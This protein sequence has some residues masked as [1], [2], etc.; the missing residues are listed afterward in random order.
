MFVDRVPSEVR[1]RKARLARKQRQW[2]EAME[3][4]PHLD[5]RERQT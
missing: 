1:L 4:E 3:S 5:E 2:G